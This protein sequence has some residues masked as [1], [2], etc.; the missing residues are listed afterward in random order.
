MTVNMQVSGADC[1]ASSPAMDA[2]ESPSLASFAYHPAKSTELDTEPRRHQHH[3]S[4]GS[5]AESFGFPGSP[6]REISM[7]ADAPPTSPEYAQIDVNDWY[8]RYLGCMRHFLDH[9]QHSLAVQSLAAFINIRLPCQRL[10]DP[11]VGMSGPQQEQQE[12]QQPP[13]QVCLR[14][15]LRRL[16]VTGN[17]TPATLQAFFGAEWQAGLDCVWKQERVNYLFSAKSGGWASTKEAYDILPDEQTPFLRPL[18]AATEEELRVAESRWSECDGGSLPTPWLAAWVDLPAGPETQVVLYSSLEVEAHAERDEDEAKDIEDPDSPRVS[19]L[20]PTSRNTISPSA[21]D[22]VRAQLL[23]LLFHIQDRLMPEYL[24]SV[25]AA[26]N[27]GSDR[28]ANTNLNPNRASTS[29]GSDTDTDTDSR[30]NPPG[31]PFGPRAFKIGHL[32]TGLFSLLTASGQYPSPL[33]QSQ[34]HG[35]GPPSP[36]GP[37]MVVPGLRVHRFDQPPYNKYLFR[38]EQF[39]IADSAD[40]GGVVENGGSSSG[41]APAVISAV[42]QG[43]NSS[44]LPP[45][46]RFSDRRGSSALQPRHYELICR[47]SAVFR[48]PKSLASF[49]GVAVYVDTPSSSSSTGADDNGED[50]IAW[51]FLSADGTLAVLHV[52]PEYRG[53]GLAEAA[54]R[55]VMRR[56]MREGRM[57]LAKGEQGRGKGWV[58]ADVTPGNRASCRVMEKLGGEVSWT[59]TWTVVEFDA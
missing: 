5:G 34:T 32:H 6:D 3:M 2:H 51:A 12:Q 16:I 13:D 53:R 56:G 30:P 29:S 58:H 24:R 52:E 41:S 35:P 54:S 23:A 39:V 25:T 22:R 31:Q 14:S 26:P 10:R 59:V 48:T 42:S 1:W 38:E 55:E 8:P 28:H 19:T 4:S 46:Y 11:I 40:T 7:T 47:R 57:F 18:R 36:H 45:G 43:S 20:R 49:P 21:L 9:A 15:Y 44:T 37:Q 17:D 27:S 33:P 50:P